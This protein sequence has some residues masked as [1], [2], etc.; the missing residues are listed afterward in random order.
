MRLRLDVVIEGHMSID[1]IINTR[2]MSMHVFAYA[3]SRL[4][5]KSS[6]SL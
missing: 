4:V 2:T 3:P 5:S 6:H 1:D